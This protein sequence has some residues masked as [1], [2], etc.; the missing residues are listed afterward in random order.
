MT[1][2]ETRQKYPFE[3]SAIAKFLSKQIDTLAGYK[4]QREI[5]AAVGYDKPNML[6]M[7]KRGETRVPI[8]KIPLLARALEVEPSFLFKL[9]MEQHWPGEHKVISEIFGDVLSSNERQ[10]VNYAREVTGNNVPALTDDIKDGIK[11]ALA[12]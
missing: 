1:K 7:L 11:T 8:Q 5:A 12:P 6:S 10:L 3:D 9:A 4:T 2:T